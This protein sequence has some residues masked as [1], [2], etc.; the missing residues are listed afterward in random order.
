VARWSTPAPPGLRARGGRD[1]AQLRDDQPHL[2]D[3]AGADRIERTH[4]A[5]AA[6]YR[7]IDPEPVQPTPALAASDAAP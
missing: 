1:S 2:A 4:L 6:S 3:L 7:A 5:E